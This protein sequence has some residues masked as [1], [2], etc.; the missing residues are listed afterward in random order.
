MRLSE[1]KRSV[2]FAT[3]SDSGEIAVINDFTPAQRIYSNAE[4]FAAVR[5]RL[6]VASTKWTARALNTKYYVFPTVVKERNKSM[7]VFNTPTDFSMAVLMTGIDTPLKEVAA[8][9]HAALRYDVVHT[10]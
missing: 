8:A 4:K 2:V 1:I 6:V 7:H 9:K 5:Y 10:L 3:I